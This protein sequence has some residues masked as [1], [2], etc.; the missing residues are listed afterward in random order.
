MSTFTLSRNENRIR[1]FLAPVAR[2]WQIPPWSRALWFAFGFV[3]AFLL[4]FARAI[5]MSA[6]SGN[7]WVRVLP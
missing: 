7:V 1:S 2:F 6:S 3:A 5:V 4:L